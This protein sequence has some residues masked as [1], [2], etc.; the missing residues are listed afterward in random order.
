MVV[1]L[2]LLLCGWFWCVVDWFIVVVVVGVCRCSFVVPSSC[3]RLC[4][5]YCCRVFALV[6]GFGV[7][8]I[9]I[10]VAGAHLCLLRAV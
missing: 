5:F 9:V 4:R 2:R 1:M 8:V 6:I 3:L 7:L 10:D